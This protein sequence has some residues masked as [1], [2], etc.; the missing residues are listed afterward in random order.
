MT[1]REANTLDDLPSTDDLLDRTGLEFMQDVLTGRLA[2]AP[3]GRTMGFRPV[4]VEKGKV[5]FEGKPEFPVANPWRSVHGGWYGTVLDSCMGCAVMTMLEKGKFYTTLEYKVNITRALPLGM[6]V[7][8][9]GLVQ[10]AGR[11]S[12]VAQG[13]IRGAEDGRL[14][15]TGTTTCI[16]MDAGPPQGG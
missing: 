1:R 11:R 3:I 8:A 6:T 2:Y 14:Y 12:A 13:E 4:A 15:A 10:H 9:T 16:V 7:T 5:V